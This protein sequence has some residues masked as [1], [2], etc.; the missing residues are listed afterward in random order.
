MIVYLFFAGIIPEIVKGLKTNPEYGIVDSSTLKATPPFPLAVVPAAT[1]DSSLSDCTTAPVSAA[2]RTEFTAAMQTAVPSLQ[3]LDADYLPSLEEGV[4]KTAFSALGSYM[5]LPAFLMAEILAQSP[6]DPSTVFKDQWNLDPDP[7]DTTPSFKSIVQMVDYPLGTF[8]PDGSWV[9]LPFYDELSALMTSLTVQSNALT[10]M[11]NQNMADLDRSINNELPNAESSINGTVRGYADTSNDALRNLKSSF[12]TQVE[13]AYA[14]LNS[15]ISGLNSTYLS[16]MKISEAGFISNVITKLQPVLDQGIALYKY[17]LGNAT[18][19]QTLAN[20]MYKSELASFSSSL[21]S[22]QWKVANASDLSSYNSALSS[23]AA[24]LASFL[25]AAKNMATLHNDQIRAFELFSAGNSSLLSLDT[26]NMNNSMYNSLSS[27]SSIGRANF[28]AL[29]STLAVNQSALITEMSNIQTVLG[30]FVNATNDNIDT[31]ALKSAEVRRQFQSMTDAVVAQQSAGVNALS[32]SLGDAMSSTALAASDSSTKVGGS[33]VSDAADQLAIAGKIGLSQLQSLANLIRQLN[34]LTELIK[35]QMNAAATQ[36]DNQLRSLSGA[37]SGGADDL[38]G[39]VSDVSQKASLDLLFG[40]TAAAGALGDASSEAA[41]MVAKLQSRISGSVEAA[42]D[43]ANSFADSSNATIGG[44][45]GNVAIANDAAGFLS[46]GSADLNEELASFKATMDAE[47][48]GLRGQLTDAEIATDNAIQAAQSAALSGLNNTMQSV[49]KSLGKAYMIQSGLLGT[50]LSNATEQAKL[51]FEA[52]RDE[53]RVVLSLIAAQTPTLLTLPPTLNSTVQGVISQRAAANETMSANEAA[54]LKVLS[55]LYAVGLATGRKSVSDIQSEALSNSKT[56]FSQANTSLTAEFSA[57]VSTLK[58]L[59]R[60]AGSESSEALRALETAS[61]IHQTLEFLSSGDVDAKSASLQVGVNEA[62]ADDNKRVWEAGNNTVDSTRQARQSAFNDVQENA[63]SSKLA[64]ASII[65]GAIQESKDALLSLPIAHTGA[66]TGLSNAGAEFNAELTNASIVAQLTASSATSVVGLVES[67]LLENLANLQ[68]DD[69]QK[70]KILIN[71]VGSIGKIGSSLADPGQADKLAGNLA[72]IGSLTAS[73]NS[74][75]TDYLESAT[76]NQ[77]QQAAVKA[78]AQQ[79]I[80]VANAATKASKVDDIG[81]QLLSM[82]NSNN[83]SAASASDQI[84][85][86][87]ATLLLL[88]SQLEALGAETASKLQSLLAK[89]EDGTL[90]M[91]QAIQA[92]GS[93]QSNDFSSVTGIA[94][95][96]SRAVA[97]Y[98]GVVQQKI[99]EAENGYRTFNQSAIDSTNALGGLAFDAVRQLEVLAQLAKEMSAAFSSSYDESIKYFQGSLEGSST[100]VTSDFI[101]GESVI[102]QLEKIV[103]KTSSDVAKIKAK[104]S[105]EIGELVSEFKQKI[106]TKLRGTANYGNR[107]LKIDSVNWTAN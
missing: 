85:S 96:M 2:C 21:K 47:S 14:A 29:Y 51:D 59:V 25:L 100:T 76:E 55:E 92:A 39:T 91:A 75:L 7:S 37:L 33:L 106:A 105:K 34:S 27:Q 80:A 44:L 67:H 69:S 38:A 20:S 52:V 8:I 49:A 53:V 65:D 88:R 6:N 82:L 103:S 71:S 68:V 94:E 50:L 84:N 62:L 28:S 10:S 31:G 13:K 97:V 32:S 93:S 35:A 58:S 70:K 36:G 95:A 87:Q 40:N 17:S 101:K 16:P 56:S 90:S 4:N 42:N 107:K 3:I 48:S 99:E 43:F 23:N 5:A 15:T 22:V 63:A 89:V 41:L 18:N 81:S 30:H 64:I 86:N 104:E 57:A 11:A 26:S 77:R 72:A 46:D 24:L 73:L 74:S 102:G 1:F 78:A 60:G 83:Q 66:L 45:N 54:Y 61:D 79:K 19:A 12:K 98:E 9:N